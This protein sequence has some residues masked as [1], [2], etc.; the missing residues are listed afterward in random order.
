MFL[1]D[2]D[3]IIFSLKGHPT[4]ND[5]V[6]RHVNDP[7]KISVVSFMELYYGAYKSQHVTSNLAKLKTLEQSFEMIPLGGESVE[8]F[9]GL[10]SQLEK[11]GTKL[12]DF[13]LGIASCALAHNLIL[14]TGNLKHFQR[15]DGLHLVDWTRK[16]DAALC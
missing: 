4:V 15:I 3:T 5:H 14:V 12:D 1:L 16:G 6:R 10:K 13:D 9:G 2:T 8:I 11:K 7:M